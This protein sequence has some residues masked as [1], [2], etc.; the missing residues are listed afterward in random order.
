MNILFILF[1]TIL[2]CLLLLLFYKVFKKDGLFIFIGFMSI[3]LGTMGFR[4]IHVRWAAPVQGYRTASLL[5]RPATW[6]CAF[7]GSSGFP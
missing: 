2:V 6:L 7:R 4:N 3:L 1:E 5:F